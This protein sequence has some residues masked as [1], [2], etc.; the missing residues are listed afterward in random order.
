MTLV[1]FRETRTFVHIFLCLCGAQLLESTGR[2]LLYTASL[3]T[4]LGSK[5]FQQ[6]EANPPILLTSAEEPSSRSVDCGTG[7]GSLL[8]P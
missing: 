2:V 4:V 7:N 8:L 3:G 1:D 6:D 5:P